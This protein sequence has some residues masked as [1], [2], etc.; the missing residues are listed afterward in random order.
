MSV[1]TEDFIEQLGG[2]VLDHRFKRLSSRLLGEA[3]VLYVEAGLTFKPRWVSTYRLL[4]AE[5]WLAIGEIATRLHM[6]HPAVIQIAGAMKKAGLLRSRRDSGDARRR[7]LALSDR[8]LAMRK[9][10]EH[11]WRA[12][13]REQIELFAVAGVDILDVLEKVS[14]ELDA[15]PLAD[16]VAVGAV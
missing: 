3:E 10:L 16:R 7:L 15:R 2:L 12:L 11:L 6:S 8:G 13:E 5:P 1:A 4:E 14:A 9:A